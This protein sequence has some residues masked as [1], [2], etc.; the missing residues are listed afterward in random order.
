MKSVLSACRPYP[1]IVEGSFNPEL[2]TANLRHVV[3]AYR[4]NA[5]AN[6]YTDP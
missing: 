1:G 3:Q 2:F 4:G 6:V 5:A